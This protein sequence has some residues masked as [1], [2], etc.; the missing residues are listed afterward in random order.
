MTDLN[1]DNVVSDK[2]KRTAQGA[3]AKY[4]PGA[5]GGNK[6]ANAK[7][8]R[9][10]A[11]ALMK[12]WKEQEAAGRTRNIRELRT[13]LRMGDTPIDLNVFKKALTSVNNK[14]SIS[15]IDNELSNGE[16][17]DIL[18]GIAKQEVMIQGGTKIA[19]TANQRNPNPVTNPTAS[20]TT[21]SK[22][23]TKRAKKNNDRSAFNN[24]Q[25]KM[26]NALNHGQNQEIA[27]LQR[28][29]TSLQAQVDDFNRSAE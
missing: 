11:N 20:N 14:V 25:D 5:L 3:A 26:Q 21:R 29:V 23:N 15:D 4:L 22:T 19:Q 13:W 8:T 16:L 27:K 6:A 10:R 1:E 12:E 17:R 9:E 28:Q 24:N 7:K 18:I 2:L